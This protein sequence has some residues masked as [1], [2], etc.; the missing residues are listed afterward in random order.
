MS[1]FPTKTAL[2]LVR[3]RNNK[4]PSRVENS[5]SLTP[6]VNFKTL[7]ASL[8][9][10]ALTKKVRGGASRRRSRRVKHRTH[11]VRRH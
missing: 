1:T 7:P 6:L 5:P 4:N 9:Q 2:T 3:M 10:Y 8:Q 11:R